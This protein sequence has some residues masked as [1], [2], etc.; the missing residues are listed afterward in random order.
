MHQLKVTTADR[1]CRR[2]QQGV[3]LLMVL[4]LLALV[5]GVVA[6]FQFQSQ[7][8]VRLAYNARD[9]LQA[10]YNALSALRLRA[11]LLKQA[12]K[13]QQAMSMLMQGLGQGQAAPP[14]GQLL[15]MIPVE[16]GIMSAITQSSGLSD[17]KFG[18]GGS[19]SSKGSKISKPGKGS[20]ASKGDKDDDGHDDFF[21]GECLATSESEHAKIA[22]NLLRNPTN[23][24]QQQVQQLLLGLLSSPQLIKFYQN[25]DTQGQH[26][27][28]PVALVTS[29]TDY[30]DSDHVVFGGSSGDEDRPYQYLK[31]PFRA[32]NAP[33]D[34]IAEMQQIHGI[35]D[36]LY[37]LLK[38]HVTIYNS[39]AA[40]E[41]STAPIERILFYGLPSA[42]IDPASQAL[43]TNDVMA[44]LY[45]ELMMM[46]TLGASFAP[47]TVGVLRTLLTA[48]GIGQLFDQ[49]KLGQVFTDST[50]TTWFTLHAEGHVGN[51]S[52][53]ITAVF[54]ASEGLFYYVRV[55]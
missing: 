38:D 49:G 37:D 50:S 26:V 41:L 36:A 1:G 16:C 13:I 27:E 20:K 15:E 44:S 10:E 45:Q 39:S 19:K 46:K 55:D 35:N 33:L 54:Q 2:G 6:E 40:M 5:G 28:S 18:D 34:S 12:R 14:I 8:T 47:L 11:L 42:L 9:E 48:Q 23:N 31:N 29:I 30:I 25:D 17:S 7:V 4:M 51:A 3:A 22:I 43:L 53:R 32:K 52:R 24:M 21:P